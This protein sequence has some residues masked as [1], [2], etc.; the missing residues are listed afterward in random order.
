MKKLMCLLLALV[1][2]TGLC[3]C[4]GKTGGE[5]NVPANTEWTRQG[6][7]QDEQGNMI[8]VT[9]MEDVVDPGWY[10]AC[11]LGEDL[12]DDSYRGMLP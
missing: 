6:F 10:V 11:M 1:L 7:F 2:L 5:E 8:S 12:I 3:A 9:L 4:G